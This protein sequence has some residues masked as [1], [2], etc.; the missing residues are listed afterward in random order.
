MPLPR[1]QLRPAVQGPGLERLSIDVYHE[2]EVAMTRANAACQPLSTKFPH[3]PTI[4]NEFILRNDTDLTPHPML[5]YPRPGGE[6]G[7][8]LPLQVV[9]QS[10]S[11]GTSAQPSCRINPGLNRGVGPR[12]GRLREEDLPL[13]CR[14][15]SHLLRCGWPHDTAVCTQLC[16]SVSQVGRPGIAQVL[17]PRL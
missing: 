17:G 6:R 12:S 9:W 5:P 15:P 4:D 11:G 10:V 7:K 8:E 13:L 2:V 1:M 14:R 16:G 3:D